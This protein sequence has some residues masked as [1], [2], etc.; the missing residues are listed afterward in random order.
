[1][2]LSKRELALLGLLIVVGLIYLLYGFIFHPLNAQ[3]N[4]MKAENSNLSNEI[5]ELEKEARQGKNWVENERQIWYDYQKILL[6]IPQS[7]MIPNI[8]I[9]MEQSAR[10][11]G[12]KLLSISY[13]ETTFAKK[14]LEDQKSQ[15][16]EGTSDS[17]HDKADQGGGKVVRGSLVLKSEV[18]MVQAAN[19]QL[20]ASGTHLNLLSFIFKIENAPR[21]YRINSIKMAMVRNNQQKMGIGVEAPMQEKNSGQNEDFSEISVKESQ[22][23]DSNCAEVNMDVNAYYDRFEAEDISSGSSVGKYDS[24]SN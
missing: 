1:M 21:I 22:A 13:K 17:L 5:Q 20:A 11:S 14:A 8:I 6:E 7:E 24:T 23:Y 18:S 19:F 3:I 4:Q 2:S 9:F 15:P 12:V 10:D 16:S